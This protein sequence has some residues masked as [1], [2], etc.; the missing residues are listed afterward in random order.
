MSVFEYMSNGIIIFLMLGLFMLGLSYA[1]K[2]REEVFLIL[3]FL[4]LL[5]V[6]WIVFGFGI[7]I[8]GWIGSNVFGLYFIGK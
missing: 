5:S 7:Y 3:K 1:I 2:H 6:V 8:L 4:G